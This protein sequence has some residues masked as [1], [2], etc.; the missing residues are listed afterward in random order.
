MINTIDDLLRLAAEAGCS[1]PE[2]CREV[3][4]RA[5]FAQR[6]P[7]AELLDSQLVREADFLKNL[8]AELD[9]PWREESEV[10]PIEHVREK[11]PARLAL[12]QLV[13]P[14]SAIEGGE[15]RL[16]TFDPFD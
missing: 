1:E 5:S 7:V 12:G 13:I 10:A 4:Q 9:I 15:M 3:L 8:A 6:S 11:F 2:K 14:E 16:L